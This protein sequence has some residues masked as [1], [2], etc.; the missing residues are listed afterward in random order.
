MHALVPKVTWQKKKKKKNHDFSM[1]SIYTRKL[2][3]VKK[4][5]PLRNGVFLSRVLVVLREV[6][7]FRKNMVFACKARN[8]V[9]C[10]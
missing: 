6:C 4:K 5:N 8:L 9:T 7:D 3:K 1:P 10:E 2:R